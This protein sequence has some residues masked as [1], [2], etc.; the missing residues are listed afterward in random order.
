M[1]GVCLFN[2]A[3]DAGE[4]PVIEEDEQEEEEDE[5]GNH[6]VPAENHVGDAANLAEGEAHR[7]WLVANFC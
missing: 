3:L 2:V 4:D 5:E 6:D 7:M 1:A